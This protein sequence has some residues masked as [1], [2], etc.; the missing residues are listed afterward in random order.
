[1]P[2]I[3]DTFVTYLRELRPEDL[4]GSAGLMRLREEMLVRVQAAARP[5]RVTDVLF[6]EMLVQ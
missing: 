4:R 5:A 6:R 1:M 3:I 2:R